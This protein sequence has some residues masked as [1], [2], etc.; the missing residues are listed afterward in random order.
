MLPA[1]PFQA[2]FS[3][4]AVLHFP[5]IVVWT[6]PNFSFFGGQLGKFGNTESH[7]I[8]TTVKTHHGSLTSYDTP[9][10]TLESKWHLSSAPRSIHTLT[11]TPTAPSFAER[12]TNGT[13]HVTGSR[14]SFLSLGECADEPLCLQASQVVPV[15]AN[16]SPGVRGTHSTC[17][18]SPAKA[19]QG[20]FQL[21]VTAVHVHD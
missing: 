3:A 18:P 1:A 6:H 7:V 12:H 10:C 13:I 8:T 21:W 19:H 9:G 15:I 17:I 2:H 16:S 14:V 11:R 20:R 5:T 4:C